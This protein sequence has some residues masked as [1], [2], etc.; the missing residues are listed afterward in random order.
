MP[1]EHLGRPGVDGDFSDLV[2]HGVLVLELAGG[3][4]GDRF[5]EGDAAAV[6]FNGAPP[7]PA[8]LVSSGSGGGQEAEG[9]MVLG[10]LARVGFHDR[11]RRVTALPVTSDSHHG[12]EVVALTRRFFDGIDCR[13][14]ILGSPATR[15]N[16]LVRATNWAPSAG[17]EP[18]TH[19]LGNRRSI[20]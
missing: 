7:H 6:E 8:D 13:Q 2:A 9:E 12:I 11:V 1:S 14:S 4:V 10:I 18:A 16:A 19:G 15:A 20:H 17:I 5:S 3:R